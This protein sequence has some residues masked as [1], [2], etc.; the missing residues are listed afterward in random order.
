MGVHPESGR[1]PYLPLPH[2]RTSSSTW[3]RPPVHD[4]QWNRKLPRDEAPPLL[5]RRCAAKCLGYGQKWNWCVRMIILPRLERYVG[6]CFGWTDV[7][8]SQ[9]LQSYTKVPYHRWRGIM[10]NF[11]MRLAKLSVSVSSRIVLLSTLLWHFDEEVWQC[12][13]WCKV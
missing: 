12:C 9:L 4:I 5:W 2:A 13:I 8:V 10:L 3:R 1:T 7:Q 6:R 11:S